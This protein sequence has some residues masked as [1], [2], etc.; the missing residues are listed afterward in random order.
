MNK[1]ELT[2]EDQET[3]DFWSKFISDV[4]SEGGSAIHVTP[5]TFES[6]SQVKPLSDKFEATLNKETYIVTL[7]FK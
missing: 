4:K 7:T 6:I 2:P 3:Y 1:N 5:E